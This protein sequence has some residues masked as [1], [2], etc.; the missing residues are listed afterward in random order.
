MISQR[1]FVGWSA[2]I[3][4][5][6]AGPVLPLRIEGRSASVARLAPAIGQ[7][8]TVDNAHSL[9]DFTVRLLGFNRVRGTFTAWQAS[10]YY[11]PDALERSSVSFVADA[12]SISTG[13]AERDEDLKRPA[14]FDVARFPRIRFR[15]TKV[16]ASGHGFVVTGDLTIRDSTHQ[17]RLPVAVLAPLATDPF[18]NQRVSFGTQV[19]LN[20]RDFGVAG[21]AFWNDAIS[22]SLVVEIE[23]G[24]RVWNYSQLDWSTGP[25]RRSAG[26]LLFNA[27]DSGRLSAGLARARALWAQRQSDSTWD[28]SGW[29]FEKA[30]MRLAQRQQLPLALSILDLGVELHQGGRPRE[31]AAVLSRRAE[32]RLR[33]GRRSEATAD[34]RQATLLDPDNTDAAEWLRHTGS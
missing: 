1:M 18:R 25:R 4:A 12:T 9:M 26:E 33:L 3:A 23:I 27:A 29:E 7:V 17:I 10:V 22:D 11:D 5:T 20:R 15:S 32:V 28:F 31:L 24:C 14:F 30:A 8:Y 19:A 2:L 16:E 6:V 34:L 21:P 13:A